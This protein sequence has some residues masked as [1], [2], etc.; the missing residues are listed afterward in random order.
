VRYARVESVGETHVRG[1]L[2]RNRRFE[3]GPAIDPR[4]DRRRHAIDGRPAVLGPGDD[5]IGFVSG[6]L[7]QYAVGPLV[8]IT[9][10]LETA[11]E[12]LTRSDRVSDDDVR[13]FVALVERARGERHEG[14]RQQA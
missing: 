10:P 14:W 4:A 13:L 12:Q 9:G 7:V 11:L 8:L 1:R 3:P 6:L 5:G 2:R